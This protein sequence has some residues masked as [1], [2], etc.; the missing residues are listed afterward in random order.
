MCF[1]TIDAGTEDMSGHER[2]YGLK[3]RME[4]HMNNVVGHESG[5]PNFRRS[6]MPFRHFIGL[7]TLLTFLSVH[8]T[9]GQDSKPILVDYG[10]K[11]RWSPNEQSIAFVRNDSLFVKRLD[12]SQTAKFIHSGPVLSLEWI[13]DSTIV[14]QELHDTHNK[15]TVFS[16]TRIWLLTLSGQSTEIASDSCNVSDSRCRSLQLRR[17]TDRTVGFHDASVREQRVTRIR[18]GGV[19]ETGM[20]ED[21]QSLFVATKPAV[22][23][24]V[25]LYHGFGDS[26]RQVTPSENH[27]SF[28]RLA[29]SLDKFTCNA[30]NGNLVVFDTLGNELGNLGDGWAPV[31]DSQSEYAIFLVEFDSEFDVDSEEVWVAKFDGTEKRRVPSRKYGTGYNVSFAPHSPFVVFANHPDGG[32]YIL[33]IR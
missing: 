31:W 29:P 12:S 22:W 2:H 17:L 28:T 5:A 18:S 7:L 20:L 8:T 13:D 15:D 3:E 23:G 14:A 16:V 25:W 33:K 26:G 24:K 30:S 19:L 4:I 9:A 32:I 27:Y 10:S 11:P 6:R 21:S 1:A